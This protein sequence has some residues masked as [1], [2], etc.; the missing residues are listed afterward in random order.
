MPYAACRRARLS[1]RWCALLATL[2]ATVATATEALAACSCTDLTISHA[3]AAT[4]K[5]CSNNDLNFPECAR[6][7]GSV[8]NGCAGRTY[9]YTCPVGVNST[10]AFGPENRL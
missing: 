6:A 4:V 1:A 10:A 7:A 3:N 5:I 8:G 2:V 9:A